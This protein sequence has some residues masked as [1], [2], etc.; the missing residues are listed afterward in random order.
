MLNYYFSAKPKHSSKKK[1]AVVPE[2]DD[3]DE[4][5]DLF[6]GSS[7]SNDVKSKPSIPK[8]SSGL[9]DEGSDEDLFASLSSTKDSKPGGCYLR[10]HFVWCSLQ[11]FCTCIRC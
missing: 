8:D 7:K 9:F 11:W 3:S 5:D 10:F 2:S 6:G 4:G 1:K